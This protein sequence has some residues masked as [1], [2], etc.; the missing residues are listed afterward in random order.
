[1]AIFKPWLFYSHATSHK[2]DWILTDRCLL[3]LAFLYAHIFNLMRVLEVEGSWFRLLENSFT[4]FCYLCTYI[5]GDYNPSVRNINLVSH[6]TYVVCVLI[7]YINGGAYNLKSTPNDRF[8]E[9]LFLSDFLP[10]ICWERK[11][12][13]KYFSYFVLISGLG[14]EPWL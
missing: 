5:I 7:L 11:S 3:C 8:L 13:K 12:Q 2:A 4:I 6:T 14:L 9:N 10:K 1:M